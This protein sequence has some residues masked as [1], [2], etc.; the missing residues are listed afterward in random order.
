[1][2]YNAHAKVFEAHAVQVDYAFKKNPDK[3]EVAND[4]AEHEAAPAAVHATQVE[5]VTLFEVVETV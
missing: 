4:P 2:T 5:V 1:M 3:Q